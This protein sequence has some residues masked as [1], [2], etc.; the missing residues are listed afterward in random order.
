MKPK[1]TEKQI[2]RLIQAYLAAMGTV[3]RLSRE[4]EALKR[5]RAK[6][7]KAQLAS[8]TP[9]RLPSRD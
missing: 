8:Y 2:D 3:T 4:L 6:K 5:E 7:S 9:V 1:L